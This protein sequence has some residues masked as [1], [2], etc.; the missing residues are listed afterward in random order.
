MSEQAQGQATPEG[1][2]VEVS[3]RQDDS[4]ERETPTPTV[5]VEAKY[6]DKD[7]DKLKGQARKEARERAEREILERYGFD[8]FDALGN[9]VEEHRTVQEATATETDRERQAREKAEKN[10]QDSQTDLETAYAR[11]AQMTEDSALRDAFSASGAKP[12]QINT[13]LRLADRDALDVDDD[14][15][16]T[17]VQEQVEALRGSIPEL[18]VDARPAGVGETGSRFDAPS[19]I[20]DMP[21]EE[22]QKMQQRVAAGER[23]V[24]PRT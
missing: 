21:N 10:Y 3:T 1:D 7:V 17:G 11:I 24:P 12:G 9:V 23:V 18:F 13:L 20:W 6:T 8:S 2:V 22:F 16:L 4:S 15:N 19:N 14:G 5:K